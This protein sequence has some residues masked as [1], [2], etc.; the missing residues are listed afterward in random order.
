MS[1]RYSI[2]VCW[3]EINV[4][5]T[6]KVVLAFEGIKYP[7]VFLKKQSRTLRIWVNLFGSYISTVITF[8]HYYMGNY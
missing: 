4:E 7:K 6:L 3:M 1:S 5:L 8:K 2:N